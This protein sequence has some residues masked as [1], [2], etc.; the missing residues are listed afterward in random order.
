VRWIAGAFLAGALGATIV[1]APEIGA[2]DYN[3]ALA[4][5]CAEARGIRATA[6]CPE[7][8]REDFRTDWLLIAA[9]LSVGAAL[10]FTMARSR[11]S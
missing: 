5:A 2:A 6:Q 3:R 7:P 8:K 11:A 1:A 9:V 10:V 4:R